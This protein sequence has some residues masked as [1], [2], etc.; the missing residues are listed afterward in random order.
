M[1]ILKSVGLADLIDTAIVSL[2]IYAGLLWFKRTRAFLVVV[3]IIILAGLYAI[4]RY[5]GLYLTTAILQSFFAVLLIAIIV[6]FQEELRRFFER[7]ALWGLGQHKIEGATPL[8]AA[9]A[10]TASDLARAKVGALIVLSGRDPVGRHV[11]GGEELGG[12][13]SEALFLSI[14]EKN[15]PGHDGAMIIEEGRVVRFAAHLPLSKNIAQLAGVGTR[16]AAALGLSELC[17]ALSIIVSEERGVVSIARDGVLSSL[18][19]PSLLGGVIEDFLKEK[20]P[21]KQGRQW[22]TLVTRNMREK[23]IALLLGVGL[24]AAFAIKTGVVQRDFSIPIEL[25]AVPQGLTVDRM[26]PHRV[27]VTISGEER[28][29]RFFDPESLRAKIDLTGSP[30]GVARIPVRERALT[31]IP[32]GLS[33]DIIRPPEIELLLKKGDVETPKPK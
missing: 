3:G 14:F 25:G 10:G 15:S 20:F 7:V 12:K 23:I 17:D 18:R 32:R 33:I 11:E 27:T 19:D 6:I 21:P 1:D 24:W 13:P 28:A 8:V 29:F 2:L 26:A 16:H 31:G 30:E 4:S 5:F 22:K 9:L